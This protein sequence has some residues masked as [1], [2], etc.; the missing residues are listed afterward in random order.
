M[1]AERRRTG[2]R[3][4]S[5]NTYH[6]QVCVPA[7]SVLTSAFTTASSGG[8]V[9][10]RARARARARV[11]IR[12]RVMARAGARARARAMI[13]LACLVYLLSRF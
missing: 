6:K 2:H 9:R 1:C 11:R 13:P 3:S 5:P 12:V 8:R 4:M 7:F 10:I